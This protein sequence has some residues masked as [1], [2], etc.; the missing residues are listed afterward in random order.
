MD[1]LQSTTAAPLPVRATMPVHKTPTPSAPA[2]EAAHAA[3]QF[4]TLMALQLV[5]S[6][7]S[8]LDG[9]N[10][11]GPGVAGDMY[12]SLTEWELARVLASRTPMG[13]KNTIL[14]QLSEK[15]KR[16]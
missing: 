6:M 9:G 7:Q 4:E 11:M 3:E 10:L 15:E 16:P 8:S 1:K 13:L 12:S 14:Q 5:R 2:P